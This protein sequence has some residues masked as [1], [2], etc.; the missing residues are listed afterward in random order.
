[1]QSASPRE[2]ILQAAR[3]ARGWLSVRHS[4]RVEAILVLALYA[5][6]EATR[7]LVVGDGDAAVEHT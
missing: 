5:V 3:T 7:G 6:Y 2:L 1:M 4:L